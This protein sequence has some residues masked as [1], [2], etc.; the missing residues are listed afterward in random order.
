MCGNLN[1]A[2]ANDFGDEY[3]Q[4]IDAEIQKEQALKIVGLSY[5]CFNYII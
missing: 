1:S 3:I 5:F 2:S 4:V